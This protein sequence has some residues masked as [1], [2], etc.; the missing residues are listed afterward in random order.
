MIQFEV[1]SKL[2]LEIMNKE[3]SIIELRRALLEADDYSLK[4]VLMALD[5]HGH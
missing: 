1:F 2:L 4:G 5:A 3:M